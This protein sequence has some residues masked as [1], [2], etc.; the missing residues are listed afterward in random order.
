MDLVDY[1]QRLIN[2]LRRM[3]VDLGKNTRQLLKTNPLLRIRNIPG[4]P[5]IEGI[6][7][8]AVLDA[9]LEHGYSTIFAEN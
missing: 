6:R 1:N 4:N 8:V 7:T 9:I 5:Y 2:T 3:D